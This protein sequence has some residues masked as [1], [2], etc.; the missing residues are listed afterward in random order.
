MKN[1]NPSGKNLL[2]AGVGQ[3]LLSLVVL[4]FCAYLVYLA[5]TGQYDHQ[6]N[7]FAAWLHRNWNAI[8]R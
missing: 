6:V 5:I 4:A 7:R 2:F 3:R 1:H 8:T